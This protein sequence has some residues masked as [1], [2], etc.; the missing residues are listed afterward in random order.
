MKQVASA[1][2]CN[3]SSWQK[4]NSVGQRH[5]GVVSVGLSSLLLQLQ[6]LLPHLFLLQPLAVTD[7]GTSIGYRADRSARCLPLIPGRDVLLVPPPRRRRRPPLVVGGTVCRSFCPASS[8]APPAH[9]SSWH[10]PAV[11]R[12]LGNLPAFPIGP[13]LGARATGDVVADVGENIVCGKF[14]MCWTLF[15]EDAE[16]QARWEARRRNEV[17]L[18]AN[19]TPTFHLA[20][21]VGRLQKGI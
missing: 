15:S 3:N 11:S 1:C 20:S 13:G 9:R 4:I 5:V 12:G 7:A 16:S 18:R 2:A 19:Q 17:H 21:L 6:L 10:R 14:R 8:V